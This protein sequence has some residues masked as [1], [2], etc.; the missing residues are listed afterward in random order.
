MQGF[1]TQHEVQSVKAEYP[2]GCRVKLLSMNDPFTNIPKGTEGTVRK[3]DDIG[4]VHV[5]WDNGSNL[6][7]VYGIDHIQIVQ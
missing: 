2:S 3:V 7:A 1:P 5:N 6:A 4:S